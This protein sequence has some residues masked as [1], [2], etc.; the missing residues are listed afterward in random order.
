VT[1]AP[2]SLVDAFGVCAGELG[3][4]S[5]A[6]VFARELLHETDDALV[7]EVVSVL[8]EAYPVFDVVAARALDL[9]TV[10]PLDAA[11]VTDALRSLS[12]LVVIGMEADCV[13]ALVPRLSGVRIGV[14]PDLT[15]DADLGR[16]VANLGRRVELLELAGFQRWAGRSAGLL[17]VVYGADGFHATVCQTWLRAHGPDVRGRFRTIAGW[18]VLGRRMD[19][20]PR[21]LGE[22]DAHDF[23]PLV[24]A[25]GGGA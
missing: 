8:G 22:T 21:W 6:R 11:P 19:A 20:Y 16:V 10:H 3:M 15:H 5:A 12:R 2:A 13:E 4:F 23:A 9:R 7:A 1:R 24:D 17:T 25:T 18:N 14:V